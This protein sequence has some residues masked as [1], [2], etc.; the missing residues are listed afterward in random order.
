MELK[1]YTNNY[2]V[3]NYD[4]SK[5]EHTTDDGGIKGLNGRIFEGKNGNQ[6]F[7]PAAGYRDG[8]KFSNVYYS[9]Y[10]WSYSLCLDN[11]SYAYYL[12]FDSSSIDM[13]EYDRCVGFT[14]RPVINL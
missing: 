8:S 13:Y 14:I 6:M 5:I 2:W 7:I 4:P 3:N 1:N 11:P 9:C 12:V 10:L